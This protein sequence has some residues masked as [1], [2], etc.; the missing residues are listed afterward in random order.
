MEDA[1]LPDLSR[2]RDS[3][4]NPVKLPPQVSATDTSNWENRN[5]SSLTIDTDHKK[6]KERKFMFTR[7]VEP[8][9]E[10]TVEQVRKLD[11]KQNNNHRK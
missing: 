2:V 8:N 4:Q 7:A 5:I 10:L 1:K 11:T 3:K 6:R 9:D